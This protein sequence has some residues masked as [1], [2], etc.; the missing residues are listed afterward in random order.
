M[1]FQAF[2]FDLDG[3]LIDSLP[4][5][6]IAANEL[7]GELGLP[8]VSAGRVRTC[9]GDGSRL[10]LQ[11]LLP[12][13]LFSET[14]LARFLAIYRQHLTD[15]TLPFDGVPELL[16]RLQPRP[17]AVVTNKP[18]RMAH[19]ILQRLDLARHFRIIVGG[20]SFPEKKPHPRPIHE[21]LRVL[22]IPPERT[23]MIGDHHTDLRAA[24]A[25]GIKSCFCGWGYGHEDGETPDLRAASVAELADLMGV[26][27]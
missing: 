15:S 17:L 6:T 18:D 1:D 27:P 21:V 7:R 5:L 23:L 4:D 24:K 2:I 12:E 9:I 3:T 25:A 13:G 14:R 11:R 16:V 19:E 26:G 20:D 22:D 8:P 10:L